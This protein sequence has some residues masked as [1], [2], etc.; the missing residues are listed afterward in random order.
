M[1]LHGAQVHRKH[2]ELGRAS[3]PVTGMYAPSDSLAAEAAGQSSTTK[4]GL[5]S[6]TSN[7]MRMLERI[8]VSLQL[9]EPLLLV[10]PEIA[11]EHWPRRRQ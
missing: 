6:Y 3:L 1:F 4:T 2:V 11:A 10:R 9:N 5:F 8:A 7:A